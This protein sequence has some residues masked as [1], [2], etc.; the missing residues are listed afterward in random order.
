[1]A[2]QI[3]GSVG[4]GGRNTRADV[5]TVQELLN[6]VSDSQGGP[7]SPVAVDGLIGPETV[8][9][10]TRFQKKN[11]G[12]S[13]GRVDPNGH[14]LARLSAYADMAGGANRRPHVAF[15]PPPSRPD[16][17]GVIDGAGLPGSNN[18]LRAQPQV[19]ADLLVEV[20][21][22]TGA[23]ASTPDYSGAASM[24]TVVQARGMFWTLEGGSAVLRLIPFSQR[25]IPMGSSAV[26]FIGQPGTVPASSVT[27]YK[28]NP[29]A[30]PYYQAG[31]NS[32]PAK[33]V[34]WNVAEGPVAPPA[35]Y[36]QVK[37]KGVSPGYF[38][39]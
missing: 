10:V 9:A 24:G 27:F 35:P 11:F 6:R 34:P 15:L 25:I 19:P 36:Y 20:L 5:V 17:A 26:Y 3:G 7:P 32:A 1:M 13:D 16:P 39:Q 14:T 22:S 2:K 4:Q 28:N 37:T 18:G 29:A 30:A 12:W 23:F 21:M 33:P 38:N 31:N 8:G